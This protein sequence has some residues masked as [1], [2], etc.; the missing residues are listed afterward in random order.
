[1]QLFANGKCEAMLCARPVRDERDGGSA[2]AD[3]AAAAAAATADA[4][5]PAAADTDG[6]DEDEE[7]EERDVR[8]LFAAYKRDRAPLALEPVPR[9]LPV[10]DHLAIAV[11]F[12]APGTRES[13]RGGGGRAWR[14]AG[15]SDGGCALA[16][17]GS[18]SDPWRTINPRHD[19][20]Y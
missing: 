3:E 16:R 6:G 13:E 9:D 10:A 8:D 18:S 2:V 15:R 11:R 17:G 19:R 1:M 20:K 14:E 7:I 4:T 12:R 5:A